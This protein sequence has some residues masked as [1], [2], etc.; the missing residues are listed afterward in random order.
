MANQKGRFRRGNPTWETGW[1]DVQRGEPNGIPGKT[2]KA[3][4]DFRQWLDG[5]KT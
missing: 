1:A 5:S 4:N 2:E 3:M